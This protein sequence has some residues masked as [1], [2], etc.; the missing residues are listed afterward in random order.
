MR[1]GPIPYRRANFNQRKG[2]MVMKDFNF[3]IT[4]EGLESLRVDKQDSYIDSEG[5]LR[6]RKNC[7]K[8]LD[9]GNQKV[10]QVELMEIER[11]Y[12]DLNDSFLFVPVEDLDYWEK[13][14]KGRRAYKLDEWEQA[15]YFSEHMFQD[16][17]TWKR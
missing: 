15:P 7:R 11:D 8:I 2:K 5:N 6:S 4:D 16:C 17:L 14:I 10:D 12:Q 3:Q 13:H 9:P 1:S